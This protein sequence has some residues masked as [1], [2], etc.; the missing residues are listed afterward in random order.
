MGRIKIILILILKR[1][2]TSNEIRLSS[3]STRIWDNLFTR[4]ALLW[5]WLGVFPTIGARISATH[6][7]VPYM[8][9]PRQATMG[10]RGLGGLCTFGKPHNLGGSVAV[11]YTL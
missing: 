6:L 3:S 7:T 9:E 11:G 10:L 1:A 4:S 5:R 2:L 8:I